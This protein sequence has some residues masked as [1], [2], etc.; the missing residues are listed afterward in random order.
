MNQSVALSAPEAGRPVSVSAVRSTDRRRRKSADGRYQAGQ[1]ARIPANGLAISRSARNVPTTTG[2]VADPYSP[3]EQIAVSIN[4]RVDI[5]EWEYSHGRLTEAAYRNG[6]II[7]YAFE[8]ASGRSQSS[9]SMGDRVDAFS[10]KELQILTALEKA[11]ELTALMVRIVKSVGQIGARML[12]S[13]LAEG[14]TYEQLAADRGRTGERGRTAAA[15]QFR[16]L[17]ED[18]SEDWAAKGQSRTA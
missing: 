9:W 18:L 1:S 2:K 14:R 11:E 12:R 3:K 6:R 7:Q 15:D 13:V 16:T 4:R 17:L 5:L 10:A 8:R